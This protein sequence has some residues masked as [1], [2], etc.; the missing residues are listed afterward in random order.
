MI[1][2]KVRTVVYLA[3]DEVVVI[4]KKDAYYQLGY[5]V[6][7]IVHGGIIADAQLAEWCVIEQKWLT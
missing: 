4:V 6:E 7:D 1:K 3:E 2:K 5:P